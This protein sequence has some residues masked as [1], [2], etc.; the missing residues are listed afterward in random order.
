MKN[1]FKRKNSKSEL[2]SLESGL[3]IE[4]SIRVSYSKK[5]SISNT[6]LLLIITMLGLF[7]TIF[8]FIS[9]FDMEVNSLQILVFTL[10]F[11]GIFSFITLLP[12]KF[13]LLIFPLLLIFLYFF[14]DY[15][16]EFTLGF[17]VV[18]NHISSTVYSSGVWSKYY[19]LPSDLE[20]SSYATLFLIFC[21]FIF[22][23]LI[24]LFTIK[25]HSCVMGFVLTFPFIEC[26][27]YFG[28]VPNYISFF[29]VV[30]YW[31]A[32]LS[33]ALSGCKK[34]TRNKSAGFVRVGN[35]FYAKSDCNFK[36]S[37]KI[38]ISSV[39]MCIVCALLSLSM[40]SAFGYERS[41]KINNIRSDVKDTVDNISFEDV[42]YSLSR[43]SNMLTS[44]S[45][46]SFNGT[47][48]QNDNIEFTGE[49]KLVLQSS[50]IPSNDVYLKSYV[51]SVYTSQSWDKLSKNDYKSP[52]FDTFKDTNVYPQSIPYLQ[53]SNFQDFTMTIKPTNKNSRNTLVPYYAK[54][55]DNYSYVDDTSIKAKNT[56]EYTFQ[57]IDISYEDVIEENVSSLESFDNNS[58]REFVNQ[59]YLQVEDSQDMKD[60]CSVF[61]EYLNSYNLDFETFKSNADLY[62][63]LDYIRN[64]LCSNYEYTLSPGRT[65]IDEDYVLHFLTKTEKGYCSHFASAGTLFCR[66]LD[67]PARYVEGYYVSKDDF[68]KSTFNGSFYDVSIK[69]NLAHAWTEIYIDNVGWICIEFTPG[70]NGNPT[71]ADFVDKDNPD[72]SQQDLPTTQ[73]MDIVTQNEP[74]TEIPQEVTTFPEEDVTTQTNPNEENKPLLNAETIKTIKNIIIILLVIALVVAIIVVRR[75]V[76][77]TKRNDNISSND[78]KKSILES[79]KYIVLLLKYIGFKRDDTTQYMQFVKD[80]S[81]KLDYVQ[82]F[83]AVMDIVLKSELSNLDVSNEEKLTTNTFAIDLAN[84]IFERSSKIN[85]LIMKYIF[86]LI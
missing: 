44:G 58:Y 66:M 2:S 82:N 71:I 11:F 70:F 24:C 3:Y 68:S 74:V 79:Y 34:T 36:I 1:L 33:M 28:A 60:V 64:F 25:I 54:V 72:I 83:D 52:I 39:I 84:T 17:K 86:C 47:L 43:L 63:K 65:P 61:E 4:N 57:V 69:D 40:V 7:G 78:S 59:Y 12:D 27:L 30:C 9:I 50:V 38:G 6:I 20:S 55:D 19:Q 46:G 81:S 45:N 51:G 29:M 41:E 76:I 31:I 32:L 5:N 53:L 10:I 15:L 75:N 77:L 13:M 21:I 80:V 8:S 22:A 35:S 14:N 16:S 26:G 37:E 73:P 67:I 42:S 23:I 49:E 85:R 62:T 48:G 56:K 18:A